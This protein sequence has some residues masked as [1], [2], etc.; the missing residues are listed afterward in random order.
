MTRKQAQKYVDKKAKKL[1]PLGFW[2]GVVVEIKCEI[3]GDSW[4]R[5]SIVGQPSKR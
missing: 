2:H 1:R 3:T 4:F 5:I